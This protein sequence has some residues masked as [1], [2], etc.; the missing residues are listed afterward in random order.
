MVVGPLRWYAEGFRGEL[1]RLG[2]TP[3]SVEVQIEVV[4]RLSRWLA[5]EGLVVSVLDEQVVTHFL[6]VTERGSPAGP[7]AEDVPAVAGMASPAGV[8]WVGFAASAVSR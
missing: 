2:Y 1:A 6:A 5:G 3:G 4:D 7:D 8:G